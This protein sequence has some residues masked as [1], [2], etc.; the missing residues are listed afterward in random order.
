MPPPQQPEKDIP[1]QLLGVPFFWV[2][3]CGLSSAVTMPIRYG[4]GLYGVGRRRLLRR[5]VIFLYALFALPAA[6]ALWAAVHRHRRHQAVHHAV[7]PP[8]RQ[9]PD[10]HVR[11][12]AAALPGR[13]AL[14]LLQTGDQAGLVYALGWYLR[15]ANPAWGASS[16]G[17]RLPPSRCCLKPSS[18]STAT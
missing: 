3:I 12:L 5:M 18:R 14:R 7:P 15:Q 2:A 4:E 16:P 9:P 11:G 10:F 6:H 1:T 17:R 8:L 13:P